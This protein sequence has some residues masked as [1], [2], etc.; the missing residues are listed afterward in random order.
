M[1]A[2]VGAGSWSLLVA[3]AMPWFGRLFD[4]QRYATAFWMAAAVPIAGYFGWLL[5]SGRDRP[6]DLR[7]SLAQ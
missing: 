6:A 3:I 1:I 7:T 4:H 2:G 5:L